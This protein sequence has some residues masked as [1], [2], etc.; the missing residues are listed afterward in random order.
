LRF[1]DLYKEANDSIHADRNLIDK[2]YLAS[3]K[4]TKFN[5]RVVSLC[6]ASF[7]II[8]SLSVLPRFYN[9]GIAP[10]SF[11]FTNEE[12]ITYNNT[13]NVDKSKDSLKK[14]K[15]AKKDLSNTND[16]NRLSDYAPNSALDKESVDEF[17]NSSDSLNQEDTQQAKIAF[18]GSGASK[19]AVF[20]TDSNSKVEYLTLS[21][22][23]QYLGINASFFNPILP[24]GM[25]M[26]IPEIYI[27]KDYK[28]D[29]IIDDSV[30]FVASDI[31]SSEKILSITTT[32][33]DSTYKQIFESNPKTIINGCDVAFTKDDSINRAYFKYKDVWVFVSSVYVSEEEFELFIKTLIK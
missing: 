28:N 21:E 26:N 25:E 32:K 30:Q 22:Y 33:L 31:N 11:S 9:E 16:V 2:I 23:A 6:A 19:S 12:K 29:N 15:E 20:E 7:L 24:N 14:S 4:K 27:T 5:M 1:R 18:G 8:I 3:N 13:E 17:D 10:N